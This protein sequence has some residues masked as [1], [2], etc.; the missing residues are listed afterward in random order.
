MCGTQTLHREKQAFA[1]QRGDEQALSYFFQEFYPAL[2]HYANQW[3]NNLPL[4]QDIASEAF[5][6]TWQMHFKFNSFDGIKAYLYTIVRRDSFRA[7]Q[8]QKRYLQLDPPSAYDT[9]ESNTPF[10]FLVRAETCRL[11]YSALQKLSPGN[12]RVITMYYLEGKNTSEIARELNLHP[13]TVQ[14]QKLRG[15]KALQKILRPGFFGVLC[16]LGKI[17][18]STL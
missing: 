10:S 16:L 4:A 7:V 2:T 8:K 13:H 9:P 6:K 3:L 18:F 15:I 5:V 11:L 14:T 1:F 12:K 17:F